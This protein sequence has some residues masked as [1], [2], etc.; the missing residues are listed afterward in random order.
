LQVETAC[1]CAVSVLAVEL[2]YLNSHHRILVVHKDFLLFSNLFSNDQLRW[3]APDDLWVAC[4]YPRILEVSEIIPSCQT[5]VKLLLLN[6]SEFV[7]GGHKSVKVNQSLL[8]KITS[9]L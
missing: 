5:F 7:E 2:I 6:L 8:D 3:I 1:R 9:I 4:A